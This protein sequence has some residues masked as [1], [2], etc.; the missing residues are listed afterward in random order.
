MGTLK[1]IIGVGA[2]GP[3]DVEGEGYCE[4]AGE[5]DVES[6]FVEDGRISALVIFG[7]SV[8]VSIFGGGTAVLG[9]GDNGSL[10][11]ADAE[12]NDAANGPI[13]GSE[14]TGDDDEPNGL[15]KE[16]EGLTVAVLVA[17]DA[18]VLSGFGGEVEGN[19]AFWPGGMIDC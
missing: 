7:G 9:V 14:E 18:I 13:G 1:R 11:D 12:G 4:A 3:K 5:G 17:T 15:P 2:G 16:S 10:L 6:E 19:R 8:V